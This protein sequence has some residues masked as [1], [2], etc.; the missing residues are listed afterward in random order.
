[1]HEMGDNFQRE[2][3]AML[4]RMS[5]IEHD[6]IVRGR[7]LGS[8]SGGLLDDAGEMTLG[9]LSDGV[10]TGTGGDGSAGISTVPAPAPAAAQTSAEANAT[11]ATN[12]SA[13]AETGAREVN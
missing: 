8:L 1:M 2:L 6:F 13:G 11:V 4:V 7:G 9:A 5:C 12:A 3:R 10:T